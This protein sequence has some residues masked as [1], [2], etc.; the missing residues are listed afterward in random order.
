MYES[1]YVILENRNKRTMWWVWWIELH[2]GYL[3]PSGVPGS[4]TD[5]ITKHKPKRPDQR[6]A[7]NWTDQSEV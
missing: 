5:G 3:A 1:M 2:R 4:T 7:P 6:T